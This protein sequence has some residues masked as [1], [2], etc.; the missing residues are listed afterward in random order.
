MD[1]TSACG[2]TWEEPRGQLSGLML[3]TSR[4]L[5]SR[6]CASSG[7]GDYQGA[8]TTVG[9]TSSLIR[10]GDRHRTSE[11]LMSSHPAGP[12]SIIRRESVLTPG[13]LEGGGRGTR[14]LATPIRDRH[15]MPS[16][17]C[18]GRLRFITS[19]PS[20]SLPTRQLHRPAL[21]D[22]ALY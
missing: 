4:D 3:L 11:P 17:C 16:L 14:H 18:P 5:A 19:N 20:G 8:A 22:I 21:E 15:Q 10:A 7:S 13:E 12:I 6:F 9:R 2:E 1:E